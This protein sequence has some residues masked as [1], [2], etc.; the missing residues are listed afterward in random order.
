MDGVRPSFSK[1]Q[2]L[3]NEKLLILDVGD[4]LWILDQPFNDGV[5]AAREESACPEICLTEDVLASVQACLRNVLRVGSRWVLFTMS[6]IPNNK[7][8]ANLRYAPGM[9]RLFSEPWQ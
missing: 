4:G 1:Q 2:E 3:R 5:D 7:F 6:I 8:S 9:F